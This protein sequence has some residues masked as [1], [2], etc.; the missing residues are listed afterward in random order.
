MKAKDERTKQ[1]N[2]LFSS[3]KFIK[4]N[5]FE[6]Y[7]IEKLLGLRE[8]E[9]TVLKSRFLIGCFNVLLLW[10][11][12]MLIINA[13]FAMY[14]LL[15]ND[16]T[17]SNTFTLISLFQI[18]QEPLRSLPQSINALIEA[19]VSMK[20]MQKFLLCDEI[21]SDCI[22]IEQGGIMAIEINDGTFY[23]KRKGDSDKADAPAQ[24][25]PPK[26]KSKVDPTSAVAE[27][28]LVEE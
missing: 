8:K 14:V 1:A 23:W 19:N 22:E 28:T 17:P 6:N 2:E 3:I 7:F 20:R 18:L 24:G 27:S 16:L 21:M 12:P 9:M 15:G 5:A 13:T 26:D 4:V 25:S 10:L 11:S